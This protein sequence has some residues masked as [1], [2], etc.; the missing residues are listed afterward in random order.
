VSATRRRRGVD[1]PRLAVHLRKCKGLSTV[2]L[3][4]RFGRA[5]DDWLE[6][7]GGDR[8]RDPTPRELCAMTIVGL[9]ARERSEAMDREG[10]PD[11]DRPGPSE[12]VGAAALATREALSLISE[13]GEPAGLKERYEKDEETPPHVVVMA[14]LSCVSETGRM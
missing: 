1:D 5:L 14:V 11:G 3:A 13:G 10:V 12:I 9:V 6:A 4:R 7:L 2:L 8:G